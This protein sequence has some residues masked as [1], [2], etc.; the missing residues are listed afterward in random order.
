MSSIRKSERR[1]RKQRKGRH[2]HKVDNRS[3]FTIVR[4]QVEKSNE[5]AQTTK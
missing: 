4:I 5:A 3:I 2:G 1:E